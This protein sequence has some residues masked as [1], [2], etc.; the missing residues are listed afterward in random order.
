[1]VALVV[2]T[3]VVTAQDTKTP[4]QELGTARLRIAQLEA[5]LAEAAKPKAAPPTFAQQVEAVAKAYTA[6][7][8]SPAAAACKGKFAVVI[9]DGKVGTSCTL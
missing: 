8:A 4:E 7:K 5:Q 1:M 2:S 9:L 3:G 6:A